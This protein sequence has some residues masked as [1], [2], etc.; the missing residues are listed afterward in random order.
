MRDVLLLME[1]GP[2]ST[3]AFGMRHPYGQAVRDGARSVSGTLWHALL[4]R[5]CPGR[6]M[7]PR[8]RCYLVH[9]A[10]RYVIRYALA[11]Q[12]ALV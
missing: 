2:Y 1:D 9:S 6:Q 8:V 5:M 11:R 4:R 12:Y 3:R 10:K 7:R